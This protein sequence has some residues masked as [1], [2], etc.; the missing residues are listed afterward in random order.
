MFSAVQQGD[1]ALVEYY[2]AQGID[3]N[4]QHPEFLTTPLIEAAQLGQTHIVAL[5]LAK[6]AD[7]LIQ[8]EMDGWDALEVARIHRHKE[9]VN[10]LR[11]TPEE[12]ELQAT[13]RRRKPFWKVF[14]R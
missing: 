5:L 12:P 1:L 8:S 11:G 3:P 14:A 6:G 4:Y 2:L 10:L 9:I 13:L 7:P